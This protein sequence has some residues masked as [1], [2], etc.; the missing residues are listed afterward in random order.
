VAFIDSDLSGALAG[1]DSDSAGRLRSEVSRPDFDGCFGELDAARA[2]NLLP[3]TNLFSI[4]P[5]S[6]FSVGAV[7]VGQSGKAYLGANMEFSGLPLNA[8]L[9]AEQSAVLNAWMHGEPGISSLHVSETPCGHCR[10]F[11]R[12]LSNCEQ[13]KIFV[14]GQPRCL[15]ELLP[16]AFGDVP[17]NGE[18]LL[19]RQRP[20]FSAKGASEDLWARVSRESKLSYAPYSGSLEGFAIECADGRRFFGR[21]AE[22]IAFNPSVVA[23]LTALNQHNLSGS[24]N[25]PITKA[26]HVQSGHEGNCSHSLTKALIASVSDTTV[27]SKSL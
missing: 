25:S 26:V 13:L 21:A 9:H 17:E 7:A 27:E 10:Q 3:L 14:Q 15:P 5:V 22:S 16:F 24:R 6:G 18:G 19:D 8:S 12:E 4:H 11:L 1:L 2:D 23:A 20:D